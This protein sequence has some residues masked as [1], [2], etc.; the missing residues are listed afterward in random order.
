MPR[1]TGTDVFEVFAAFHQGR[2][3][4]LTRL[5]PGFFDVVDVRD[6]VRTSMQRF[7][8]APRCPSLAAVEGVADDVW[9]VSGWPSCGVGVGA[10]VHAMKQHEIPLDLCLVADVVVPICAA[11]AA[12]GGQDRLHARAVVVDVEGAVRLWCA[13]QIA[14]PSRQAEST[15]LA[16][17]LADFM[18]LLIGGRGGS[19]VIDVAPELA[20]LLAPI[21]EACRADDSPTLAE[22]AGALLERVDDIEQGAARMAELV[23]ALFPAKFVR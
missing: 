13:E 20:P 9:I 15:H 17:S 12:V 4:E 1:A 2:A 21:V 3:V 6:H 22:I 23:A 16:S 19:S 11:L 5:Y 10:L 18:M 8:H 14:R 7:V